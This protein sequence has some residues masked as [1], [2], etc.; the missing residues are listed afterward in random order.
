MHQLLENKRCKKTQSDKSDIPGV[1][2]ITFINGNRI[3]SFRIISILI[4]ILNKVGFSDLLINLSLEDLKVKI[5]HFKVVLKYFKLFV[6]GIKFFKCL[7]LFC[8]K[9]QLLILEL[10]LSPFNHSFLFLEF[11]H[12]SFVLLPLLNPL[13]QRKR[14]SRH[15]HDPLL[16][17]NG[18]Q[19]L[20]QVVSPLTEC[21][22][23][24]VQ[25]VFILLHADVPVLKDFVRVSQLQ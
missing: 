14:S 15:H 3:I 18:P 2:A 9:C 23:E 10:F 17:L 8:L 25:S 20:I 4:L 22:C 6:P 24:G 5:P 13:D 16:G 1:H 11:Y 7:D 12:I 19:L 21:G